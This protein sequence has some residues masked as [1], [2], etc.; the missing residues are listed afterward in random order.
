VALVAFYCNDSRSN[1]E[2]FEYYQQDIEALRK[3][4]HEVV[5]C[6][7]Y[8]D[9]PLQFDLM[10][11]WWWTYALYPVLLARLF[12]RP[13][14]VTGTYNFRF[15]KRFDGV[16]YFARPMWQR[17]LIRWATK[18]ATLNLFVNRMEMEACTNYFSLRNAAYMPHVLAD[19][20]LMGPSECRST[21]LFNIAW[22]GKQNLVRKG[23]PELLNAVAVLRGEF[24]DI[25]LRLAGRAGDGAVFLQEMINKLDL[26]DVVEV[27]GP[28]S[29]TEKIRQLRNCEIFVQ[30]SHYEGFGLAMAEAMGSGACIVTC[31]VGAVRDVV[32]DSGV[33]VTPGSPQQLADAIRRVLAD[34]NLREELQRRAVARARAEFAFESKLTRLSKY[35]GAIGL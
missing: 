6:N 34:K 32:A 8:R 24:A 12:G 17:V 35:L 26:D 27:L 1:I 25:R 14:I 9:I 10:F 21:S 5:V 18:L 19:E 20:Y 7:R 4:G 11:V 3:L 30:P 33:Y 15:P 13:A 31:D 2:T 23:I 28:I 16:D 22:S 29:K